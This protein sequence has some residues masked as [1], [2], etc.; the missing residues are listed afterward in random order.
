MAP[1]VLTTCFQTIATETT[2][3]S[4]KSIENGSTFVGKLLEAKSIESAI[5]IQ[6]EY[7]STTYAGLV[8]YLTKISDLYSKL[9]KE[10]LR[11]RYYV[12]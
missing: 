8:A 7:A 2:D 6:S 11:P 9:A 1:A 4:K 5:R 12:S 3:F 10:G